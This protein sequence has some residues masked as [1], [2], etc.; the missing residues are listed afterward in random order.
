M[1]YNEALN[2]I[3]SQVR[4][5]GNPAL[6]RVKKL[7]DLIDNP[8][9]KLKFVHVGGTNGK[10]TTCTM[11]ASVLKENGYKMGLFTSPYVVDFR[12][13]FQ[14][15]GEMIPENEFTK[16]AEK[17]QPIADEMRENGD[18]LGQFEC[19]TAIA[20]EWFLARKCDVVVLEVGI[21]GR[22][23]ATNVIK[24]PLVSVITSIS[25]DHTDMLGDT[26]EKIAFEKAGIIKENSEVVLYPIQEESAI[27][28]VKN[29]C[30]ERKSSLIIPTVDKIEVLSENVL[31]SEFKYKGDKIAVSFAG[32]HQ[33]YNAV[34]AYEAIKVIEKKGFVLDKEKIK[35]GFS[36]AFIPARMEVLSKKPLFIIDGGHNYGCA[37]AVKNVLSNLPQKNKVTAVFGM[38]NDKDSDKTLDILAPFFDKIILTKPNDKRAMSIE[39]LENH[40]K[41]FCANL[42]KTE[43]SDDATELAFKEW[44]GG[45]DVVVCGSFYLASEIRERIMDKLKKN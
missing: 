19:I 25:L 4:L 15:N 33:I 1:T 10:G 38:M 21:G 24:N 40:A 45:N 18:T 3:S 12:E 11:V 32:R 7:L 41:K 29:A 9:D 34:T 14:I 20:F 26:V 31:G 17:I 35:N 39:N 23:D 5:G 8:Q 22:F 36:K 30:F 44:Q 6:D 43:N 28:V 27:N 13:R 42:I 2:W 37:V 16:I